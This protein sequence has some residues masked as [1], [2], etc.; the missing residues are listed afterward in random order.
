[1][2]ILSGQFA[3][4][5]DVQ[6]FRTE[7]EAAA[8]LDHPH[9]VPVYDFG[10]WRDPQ[11]GAAVHYFAMKFVEG[12]SFAAL[13]GEPVRGERL[14]EVMRLLVTVAR[15]VHHA[16]QRGILHRDLKPANILLASD[17]PYVTDFGLA[18]RV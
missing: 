16:H 8:C 15:A 1:K 9:I 6:R 10:E 12:S 7:V 17:H 2:M 3:S 5:D 11:G 18:R 4:A 14:A 13:V